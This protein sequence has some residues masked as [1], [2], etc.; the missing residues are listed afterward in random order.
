[1]SLLLSTAYLP[2]ISYIEQCLV[3]GK[4]ILESQEHYVKQTYRNRANIY[5]ANGMLSLIIP[6]QHE[7]LA[8]TPIKDVKISYD[9]PW[10]QTHW[11]SIISAYRNSPYFEY[12]EHDFEPFYQKQFET[13]FDFNTELFRLIFS[14]LKAEVEISFTSAY[15]KIPA[16]VNDLRNAFS[17]E[18]RSRNQIEYR[19]VF[20][21]KHGF[22]S[23]LSIIDRLFNYR[24]EIKL[25]GSKSRLFSKD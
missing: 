14:L 18:K 2:P 19:Q 12:Y 13:L 20:F 5:G 10:Q 25:N 7:N 6:V 21:E 15:E 1:M 23:D 9:T 3:S 8:E 11:R 24:S 17:P 22:I 4:I 16:G